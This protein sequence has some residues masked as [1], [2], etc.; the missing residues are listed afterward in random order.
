MNSQKIKYQLLSEK[1]A[2]IPVEI[3][4]KYFNVKEIY[5]GYSSILFSSFYLFKGNIKIN[6]VFSSSII[7]KFINLLELNQFTIEYIKKNYINK[8]TNFIDL[9]LNK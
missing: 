7:K 5:S 2:N 9:D 4:I 6:A 1:N 3:I 8:N